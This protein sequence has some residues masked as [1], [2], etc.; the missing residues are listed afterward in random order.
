MLKK[1]QEI[2]LETIFASP[3]KTIA[4]WGGG[5]ALSEIYLHHRRSDDVDIILTDLP[6]TTELSV[7]AQEIKLKLKAKTVASFANMNRFQYVF[8]PAAGIQKL[9]FIY[10]PFKKLGKTKMA[11][12]IKIESLKDIC[13]SKTLAAYQRR[14]VK[15]AYDFYEIIS[16]D[17][18]SLDQLVKGVKD[19]FGEKIDPPTL[20][21]KINVSLNDFNH[22][23]P[24]LYGKADRKKI[25]EFFQNEFNLIMSKN[26]F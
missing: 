25:L 18:F 7:L 1:E 23:K 5:T 26:K 21:A 12:K 17:H 4:S 8:E 20:L 24:L 13:V 22:L 15:D 3:V 10:Y 2:I 6:E 11:G 14:E 9:E 19:K 16:N